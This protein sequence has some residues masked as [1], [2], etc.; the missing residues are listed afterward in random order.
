MPLI[1]QK[2]FNKHLKSKP[3]PED[4][5]KVL[6]AW[7]QR[8]ES[9]DLEKQTEVSVHAPFM[10]QILV[11]VLGYQA[12]GEQDHYTVAREYGIARGQVDF[13]LGHLTGNKNK[14]RIEAVLEAKGA[15][16]RD[17]DAIMPG[18][19]I[20]PVQ[21]VWGYARDAKGAQWVLLTNYLEIRLYHIGETSLVYEHFDL[22]S[23]TDPLEYA[24]FQCCLN[25]ENLLNGRTLEL[26][27]QTHQVGKE[28]TE[29]L[30]DDYKRLRET[31]IVSLIEANP[32][33]AAVDLVAPAQKL[34]DRI[35]FVAFAEDSGLIPEHSIAQAYTHA[36]PYNPRPV[37]ENF[38]GLFR[39]IDK[40]NSHLNIPAYNGG[41]FA[42]DPELDALQVSDSLCEAFKELADYDFASEVSVTVLGHIFEQS[43]ADLEELTEQ[44]QQGIPLQRKDKARSVSGKRKLQGVVYT[45]DSITAFI[46]EQTLGQY[47]Q[48]QFDQLLQQYGQIKTDGDIQWKKGKQTELRFWY[49]WQEALQKTRV[50]DPA[51]GSGAFLVAAFDYLHSEYQRINDKLTELTGQPGVFDLNKEILNRNLYGVDIN[52]ESIE[53]TKLSLWLKTAERGKPLTSLDACIRQGNSLGFSSAVPGSDFCWQQAFPEIFAEGGFDLVLGNPPYVRQERFSALKPWLAEQYQV[54]H[55]VADL[56]AYF[57]ELGLNLLKPDGLLGYIS[58]ST[59]FKTSSGQPL[60]MFLKQQAGF[61]KVVDFGDLQVFEGVTTYPAILILQKTQPAADHRLQM[62]C[63]SDQL[64]DNL[65]QA[66]NQQHGQMPQQQLQDEGWQ[67]EDESLAALRYKLTHDAKGQPYPTIK[68]IYGSP[69]RGILTG[70]NEAF[71][72]D[73]A[74]RDLLVQQDPASA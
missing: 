15:R 43:I 38:K 55:G 73:Q 37:Y 16:T 49:A 47:L 62:L 31:L 46:V 9:G 54:Y 22:A 24:R 67:L 30:Y 39:A 50:V 23:L 65:N 21:Q 6:A 13:V 2:V 53:I 52:P 27:Q 51:C 12:F 33:W 44:L 5:W 17:L 59:F 3:L 40:G 26:L 19:H 66:F 8:I 7:K 14:D 42:D 32:D 45:P 60:R 4:H 1:A 36:D 18:R 48:Q 28:I 41:L 29:R 34:L 61:S 63:L 58:S 68:E 11:K 64:P 56:Y 69:Y 74:T 20:S 70:L 72:I 57:F 10:Q 71:V 35:L 25:A